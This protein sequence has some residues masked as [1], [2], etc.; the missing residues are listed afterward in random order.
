MS[1]V[2]ARRTRRGEWHWADYGAFPAAAAPAIGQLAAGDHQD[3]H[4]QQEQ[5]IVVWTPFT[6][7]CKS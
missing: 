7:V 1:A 2:V 5:V 3:R 6:S 4:D